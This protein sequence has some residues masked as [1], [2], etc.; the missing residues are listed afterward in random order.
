MNTTTTLSGQGKY[1]RAIRD[2]QKEVGRIR[3]SFVEGFRIS[4]T[5]RGVLVE[6]DDMAMRNQAN[7]LRLSAAVPRWG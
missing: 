1:P 7:R 3:P 2:L 4:H 6:A 5:S